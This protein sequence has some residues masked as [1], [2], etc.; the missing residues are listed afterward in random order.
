MPRA[1]A[2]VDS[3]PKNNYGKVPKTALRQQLA[4]ADALPH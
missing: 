4:A 3:L 2:L 1:Y